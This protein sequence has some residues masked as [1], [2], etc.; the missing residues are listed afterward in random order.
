MTAVSNSL[1]RQSKAASGSEAQ[2]RAAAVQYYDGW[3]LIPSCLKLGKY[4][5]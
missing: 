3:E 4:M 1:Q 2:D 5:A